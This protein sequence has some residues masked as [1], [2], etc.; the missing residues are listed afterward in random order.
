MR[1]AQHIESLDKQ[2]YSVIVDTTCYSTPLPRTFGSVKDE[3]KLYVQAKKGSDE[4]VYGFLDRLRSRF[5]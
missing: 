4:M 3:E 1:Y 5:L 2:F